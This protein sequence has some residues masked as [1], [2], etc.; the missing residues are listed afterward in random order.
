MVP[1]QT[2]VPLD[3]PAVIL[4]GICGSTTVPWGQTRPATTGHGSTSPRIPEEP[5]V[6]KAK[7]FE[8]V[9]KFLGV[10][11]TFDIHGATPM[12]LNGDV[13][14]YLSPKDVLMIIVVI[15]I[16]WINYRAMTFWKPVFCLTR[17]DF[18][19]LL[20]VCPWFCKLP[21]V[22]SEKKG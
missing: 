9:L 6:L 15:I 18:E 10:P 11:G 5:L 19:H 13:R 3:V 22:K 8:Y 4:Q 21:F 1:V 12:D 16:I 20:F 7:S 2:F 14:E 17:S